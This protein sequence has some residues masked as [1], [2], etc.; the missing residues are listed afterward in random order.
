M[1]PSCLRSFGNSDAR[2]D[3]SPGRRAR[4]ISAASVRKRLTSR[5]ALLTTTPNSR[6]SPICADE[7]KVEWVSQK[8]MATPTSAHRHRR[9][10]EQREPD[11]LEQCRQNEEDECQ[12]ERDRELEVLLLFL[13][14]ELLPRLFGLVAVREFDAGDDVLDVALAHGVGSQVLPVHVHRVLL[15]LARDRSRHLAVLDADQVAES[16]LLAFAVADHHVID[17]GIRHVVGIA[18]RQLHALPVRHRPA[19]STGYRLRADGAPAPPGRSR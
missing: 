10:D 15:V 13:S 12:R 9:E 1:Q 19:W 6:I 18:V 3:G 5:I 17:V 14:K 7:S 4:R 16:H 8:A 11:A 2:A